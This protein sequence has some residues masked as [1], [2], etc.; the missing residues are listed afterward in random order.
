[1]I[2]KGKKVANIKKQKLLGE[3]AAATKKPTAE[4]NPTEKKPAT[5]EKKPAA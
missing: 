3:R 4:K 1:V 5:E 2:K